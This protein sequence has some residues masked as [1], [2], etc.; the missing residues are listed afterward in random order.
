[1]EPMAYPNGSSNACLADI[2]LC[3][4][5]LTLVEAARDTFFRKTKRELPRKRQALASSEFRENI[6]KTA[7]RLRGSGHRPIGWQPLLPRNA[8]GNKAY[9]CTERE[10]C[11]ISDRIWL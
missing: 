5:R 4:V 9:R 6:R 8:Q 10:Q 7:M 3:F 11:P 1:M 2:S